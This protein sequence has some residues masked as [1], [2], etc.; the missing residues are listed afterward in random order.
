MDNKISFTGFKN[1]GAATIELAGNELTRVR[2]LVVE[3][4][5]V[6]TP[7]LQNFKKALK[8]YPFRDNGNFLELDIY[9]DVEPNIMNKVVTQPLINQKPLMWDVEN[10]PI[11]KMIA[12]LSDKIGNSKI[13]GLQVSDTYLKSPEC[14]KNFTNFINND[15]LQVDLGEELPLNE[16]HSVE[17]VKAHGKIFCAIFDFVGRKLKEMCN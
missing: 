13:Q 17:E 15:Y 9:E 14:K 3:L 7:D 11:L 2:H 1:V 5:N 12:N 6:G 10:I 16:L 4:D 8:E